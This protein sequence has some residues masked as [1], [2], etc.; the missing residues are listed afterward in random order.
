MTRAV[1]IQS[2]RPDPLVRSLWDAGFDATRGASSLHAV[3]AAGDGRSAPM[4]AGRTIDR[5]VYLPVDSGA[6]SADLRRLAEA[7]LRF[8][9]VPREPDAPVTDA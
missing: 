5:I 7:V 6:G 9:R 1:P 4:D 3:P 8:E 2:E